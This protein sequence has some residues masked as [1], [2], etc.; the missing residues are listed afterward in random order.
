M[1]TQ[2]MI[3]LRGGPSDGERIAVP[4][5]IAEVSVPSHGFESMAIYHATAERTNDGIELWDVLES[6]NT[7]FSDTGLAPL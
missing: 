2:K 4:L 5:D 3:E 6:W 1:G 7:G